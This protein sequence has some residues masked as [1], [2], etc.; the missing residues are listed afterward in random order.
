MRPSW[1]PRPRPPSCRSPACRSSP[2]PSAVAVVWEGGALTYAGLDRRAAGIAARLARLGVRRDGLV[3]LSTERSGEAVAALLGILK[4]GAGYLLLDP[5]H[6]RE[7][8]EA[9]LAD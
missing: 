6:P 1:A 2:R 4:A 8:L 9:L 3:A 5:A 7:R